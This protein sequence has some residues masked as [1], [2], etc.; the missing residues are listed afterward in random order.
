[1]KPCVFGIDDAHWID[2]DSWLFLLDLIREPN[3]VLILTTRPLNEIEKPPALTQILEYPNTKVLKLDGLSPDHMVELTCQLLSV[4]SIPED[5]QDIVNKKSH[6][7]PLWCEELV[8]TMLELQYLKI[9]EADENEPD[10]GSEQKCGRVVKLIVQD[11]LA[12]SINGVEDIPIPDSVTGMVLA[13]IDHMSADDQMTLKCAAIIGTSFTKGMLEAIIPN[14]NPVQFHKSLNTLAEAG[15]IECSVAAKMKTILIEETDDTIQSTVS[16]L[17]CSCLEKIEHPLAQKGHASYLPVDNC[18]DLQFVHHY[19]QETTYNLFTEAQRKQLHQAAAHFLESKAHKCKN[20]GG[21]DFMGGRHSSISKR[22]NI[23]RKAFHGAGGARL[24][25][26]KERARANSSVSI[27]GNNPD[28][29]KNDCSEADTFNR[30]KRPSM[31]SVKVSG[32]NTMLDIDM[33]ECHC[34]H[35]LASVYP[36][37]VRHWR[38]AGEPHN[39]MVYLIEEASAAVATYNNMEATS[40]LQEA[41]VL[42]TQIEPNVVTNQ[43]LGR[44]Q[45][46]LGQVNILG[47]GVAVTVG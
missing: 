36:Q 2:S 28:Q 32:S 27:E 41:I 17:Q 34:D 39:T 29:N 37:L 26:A 12:A 20:C 44:I 30:D 19:V 24:Q 40:L 8:E 1:M 35:V 5:L 31:A 45:S 3:A 7:V 38:A 43:E 10:D 4:T 13:R 15:I 14:C 16:K 18:N 21:G 47:C 23:T 11:S 46:L 25:T 33:Q 9:I 6:G 22:K 42:T